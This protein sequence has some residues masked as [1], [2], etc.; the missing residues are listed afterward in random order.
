PAVL[1]ACKAAQV[2]LVQS[3]HLVPAAHSEYSV[4]ALHAAH[5]VTFASTAIMRGFEAL[6]TEV[7]QAS[8]WVPDGDRLKPVK[9]WRVIRGGV[10][11]EAAARAPAHKRKRP[12][13]FSASRFDLAH[14]AVDALVAGFA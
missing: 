11:P 4:A 6:S 9:P 5:A 13:I 8:A 12:F 2:P 10:D 1:A 7:A 14:K 3:F